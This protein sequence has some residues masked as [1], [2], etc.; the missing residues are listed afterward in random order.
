MLLIFHV[1]ISQLNYFDWKGKED[2]RS[3]LITFFE[4]T[5]ELNQGLLHCRWILNYQLKPL[6]KVVSIFKT[7]VQNKQNEESQ[8]PTLASCWNDSCYCVV[9][10]SLYRFILFTAFSSNPQNDIRLVFLL[11][12]SV[13]SSLQ[14]RQ[15]VKT[16]CQND[17][18]GIIQ[19]GR[20]RV[21]FKSQSVWAY[22]SC[23]PRII[24]HR[25]LLAMRPPSHWL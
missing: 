22:S 23:F 11:S 25:R 9:G 10:S 7:L 3:V 17:L 4:K 13:I 18:P 21:Q 20:G 12:K 24:P 2:M 5:Q 15:E 8:S 6:W 1:Y 19:L 14:E 16:E